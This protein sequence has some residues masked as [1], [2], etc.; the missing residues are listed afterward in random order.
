MEVEES[1]GKETSIESKW[2]DRDWELAIKV[3]SHEKVEW[4]VK[5]FEPFKAPEADDKYSSFS[6]EGL[7]PSIP[8]LTEIMKAFLG[9]EY[10]PQA[11]K[12]TRVVFILKPG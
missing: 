9:L 7:G 1:L 6:Q 4:A 10:T 12:M 8:Y 2:K 11:W 3:S 5:I